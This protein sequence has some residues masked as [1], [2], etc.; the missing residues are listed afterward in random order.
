MVGDA[1]VGEVVG[2]DLLAAFARADL[3]AS[4]LVALGANPLLLHLV[5]ARPQD[6]HRSLAVLQLRPLV[7]ANDY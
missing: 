6:S 4:L 3:G 7:L 2:A 5:Q 1:L